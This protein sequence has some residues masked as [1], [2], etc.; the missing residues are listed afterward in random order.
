MTWLPPRA[1]PVSLGLPL[2]RKTAVTHLRGIDVAR[3]FSTRARPVHAACTARLSMT[4][5]SS[6]RMQLAH[7]LPTSG[8]SQ[9]F[10]C[11][12]RSAL[13]G[14]GEPAHAHLPDDFNAVAV[15][16]VWGV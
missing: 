10:W 8:C 15:H 3:R 11:T 4:L 14:H 9:L 5:M 6:V 7:M 1:L 13:E 12:S 2:A 16:I